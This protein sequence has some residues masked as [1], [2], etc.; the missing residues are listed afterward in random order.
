MIQKLRRAI[1]TVCV[2]LCFCVTGCGGSKKVP[3]VV[4]PTVADIPAIPVYQEADPGWKTNTI[5]WV[6]AQEYSDWIL[7]AETVQQLIREE[8]TTIGYEVK[9]FRHE[10]LTRQKRLMIQKLIFLRGFE[11]KKTVTQEGACFDMK[12]TVNVVNNPDTSESN[13]CE[14][15]GRIVVPKD[16]AEVLE[17]VAREG[18]RNLACCPEFRNAIHQ[19]S[20]NLTATR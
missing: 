17:S 18:L 11:L 10:Y 12:L 3:E 4:L 1:C 2:T 9:D 16:E 15:W 19:V 14:I 6:G 7:D 20:T 8:L 5:C 13:V